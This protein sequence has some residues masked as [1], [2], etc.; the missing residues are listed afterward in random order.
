MVTGA[1]DPGVGT[2]RLEGRM[3][4]GLEQRLHQA[5]ILDAQ[6]LSLASSELD[7]AIERELDANVALEAVRNVTCPGCGR[8]LRSGRCRWCQALPG[9]RSV[10]VAGDE[11][12]ARDDPR[13]RLRQDVMAVVPTALRS[14]ALYLVESLDDRGLLS[15]TSLEE[16]AATTGVDRGSA[17]EALEVVR[18]VGPA[19]IGAPDAIGALQA[20]LEGCVDDAGLVRLTRELLEA[21]LGLLAAGDLDGLATGS[22]EDGSRIEA[23]VQ[24]L[25]R[26][27][28][29]PGLGDVERPGRRS[30]GLPPPDIEI[31]EGGYGSFRVSVLEAERWS[32]RVDPRFVR[33]LTRDSAADSDEIRRQVARARDFVGRLE[34]RWRT[35]AAVATTAVECHADV[36]RRRSL[37]FGPLSQVAVADRLGVAPST[38]SRAVQHR[39]V[40]LPWGQVVP[41][42]RLFGVGHDVRCVLAEILD[43]AGAGCPDGRLVELLA[44]RGINIARRTVAKYR[45][46]L[47]HGRRR[48]VTVTDKPTSSR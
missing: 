21:H 19:G 28:P 39:A 31:H 48:S 15:G 27:H 23:A 42:Q 35:L 18:S 7:G 30:Q 32:V 33:L 4:I 5:A 43:E 36:L 47:G 10:P 1:F 37:A 22:G 40:R 26:L 45:M 16:I 34:R 12:V 13:D 9:G 38:V 20:Q 44:E 11:P 6:F 24:L 14:T 25:Q 29:Y 8:R 3:Q 46:Q 41:L 17:V 2:A